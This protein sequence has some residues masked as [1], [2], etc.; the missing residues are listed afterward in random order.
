VWAALPRNGVISPALWERR[1]HLILVLL[2]VHALGVVCLGLIEG[3]GADVSVLQGVVI[4][5][6]AVLAGGAQLGQRTRALIT[7]V[8][9]LLSSA[10][11]VHLADGF[12]EM[13]VDFA[14]MV[15]I[16][17]LYADWLPFLLALSYVVA[18]QVAV[19]VTDTSTLNDF[20]HFSAQ[21]WLWLAVHLGFV[22]VAAT[23]ALI[24]WRIDEAAHRD[25]AAAARAAEQERL[26]DTE[27]RARAI[28]E[29]ALHAREEL[30]SIVSHE[31]KDP[32]GTIKGNAQLLQ[33]QPAPEAD[34]LRDS[35]ALIDVS[36]TRMA[37]LLDELQDVTRLATGDVPPLQPQATDVIAIARRVA[38]DFQKASGTHRIRVVSP[39][40]SLI[41]WWDPTRLERAIAN[42]VLQQ[43]MSAP[44]GGFV[45]LQVESEVSSGASFVTIAV[46]FAPGDTGG[47]QPAASLDRF[48]RVAKTAGPDVSV[49]V[50]RQIVEQH[51]GEVSRPTETNGI[52][53]V[54]ARLP[55]QPSADVSQSLLLAIHG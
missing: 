5:G 29:S 19:A 1:H 7:T 4:V 17:T 37:A 40:S 16:V 8:G 51:G 25:D 18:E 2:W 52:S 38:S 50:A 41:G 34:R 36:A 49:F 53:V 14:V 21:P 46:Q 30:L 47:G 15:A 9:L 48:Q 28:T 24:H 23:A 13:H 45:D 39:A 22:L 54:T 3:R 6:A 11:L 44:T 42:L 35:L 26:L 10:L 20:P 32:L 43:V 55:I 12:V 31:L 33:R 27:R